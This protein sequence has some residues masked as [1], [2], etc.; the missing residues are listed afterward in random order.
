MAEKLTLKI[1]ELNVW[2]PPKEYFTEERRKALGL[3]IQQQE[4]QRGHD[5]KLD[6]FFAFNVV[7]VIISAAVIVYLAKLLIVSF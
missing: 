2:Q 4:R 5:R 1:L 6:L 3:K 7:F